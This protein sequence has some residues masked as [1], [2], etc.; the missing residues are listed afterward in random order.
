MGV[1]ELAK[2]MLE[3]FLAE[4]V[5][6]TDRF[7][8]PDVAFW[9]DTFDESAPRARQLSLEILAYQVTKQRFRTSRAGNPRNVVAVL[10]YNVSHSAGRDQ[11][12]RALWEKRLEKGY[13]L[14]RLSRLDE[15]LDL[16]R[17]LRGACLSEQLVGQL[18]GRVVN[19]GRIAGL[20]QEEY[21]RLS[22]GEVHAEG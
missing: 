21:E 6:C 7:G 12:R 14:D 16:L 17:E 3:V 19:L 18:V 22:G 2:T 5:L 8:E 4:M 13:D 10:L 20:V 15:A 1:E 11:Q 9:C